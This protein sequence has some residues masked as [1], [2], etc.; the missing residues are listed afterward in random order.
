MTKKEKYFWDLTGYLI[1]P[2]V[3]SSDEIAAANEGLDYAKQS[4]AQ[5]G[6]RDYHPA[7]QGPGAR[8]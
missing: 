7:L 2:N 1:I 6:Q 3:L 4:I 5:H 8:W